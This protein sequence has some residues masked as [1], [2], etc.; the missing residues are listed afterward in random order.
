TDLAKWA[1]GKGHTHLRV[2]GEFIPVAPWPRLDRYKEHTIELPVADLI[3]NPGD[4]AALREAV[5]SALEHGQG[6]MSLL[7]DVSAPQASSLD[8]RRSTPPNALAQQRHF[9]VK[10]A[11]PSCGTSFPEPDP[12]M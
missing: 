5:R 6:S 8:E 1:A 3:V 10:R 2:D 12:R 11:C 7:L 9:S 4:E